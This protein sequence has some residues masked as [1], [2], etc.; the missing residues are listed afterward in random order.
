MNT[1]I[2]ASAIPITAIATRYCFIFCR[3]VPNFEATV[4][5]HFCWQ[6]NF[7]LFALFYLKENGGEP[8]PFA[9][10]VLTLPKG[11]TGSFA[12]GG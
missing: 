5:P 11:G 12:V 7:I 8:V 9:K 3:Q 2:I 4:V 1:T 6:W 10:K